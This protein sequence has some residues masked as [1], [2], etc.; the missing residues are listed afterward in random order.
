[1]RHAYRYYNIMFGET[2]HHHDKDV[3]LTHLYTLKLDLEMPY[4][5]IIRVPFKNTEYVMHMHNR[6][7]KMSKASRMQIFVQNCVVYLTRQQV[8]EPKHEL[9]Q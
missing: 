9:V 6:Y 3:D 5:I 4:I 2:F 8:A 1:M 7:H